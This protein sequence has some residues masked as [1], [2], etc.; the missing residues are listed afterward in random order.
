MKVPTTRS[1]R[2]ASCPEMVRIAAL[3]M[4]FQRR[5][6]ATSTRHTRLTVLQSDMPWLLIIL[7]VFHGQKIALSLLEQTNAAGGGDDEE[8]PEKYTYVATITK[9]LLFELAVRYVSCGVLFRMAES[10]VR[11]TSDIFNTSVQALH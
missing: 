10:I 6:R 11:H 2:R 5:N 3:S 8:S 1:Q 9:P 4:F 7:Q